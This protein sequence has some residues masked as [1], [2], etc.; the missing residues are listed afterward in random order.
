MSEPDRSGSAAGRHEALGTGP[1]VTA[2]VQYQPLLFCAMTDTLK[3]GHYY[4]FLF[5]KKTGVSLQPFKVKSKQK[6]NQKNQP[7]TTTCSPSVL[8]SFPGQEARVQK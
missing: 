6:Q 2:Q 8:L 1:G 4:S 5:D 3:T 7:E